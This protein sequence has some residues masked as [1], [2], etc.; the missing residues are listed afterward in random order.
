M[1]HLETEAFRQQCVH[2]GGLNKVAGYSSKDTEGVP[3]GQRTVTC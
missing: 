1:L 2:T 3:S